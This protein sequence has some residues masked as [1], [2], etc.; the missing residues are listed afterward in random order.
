MRSDLLSRGTFLSAVMWAAAASAQFVPVDPEQCSVTIRTDQPVSIL[1][2]PDAFGTPLSQARLF[3]GG[4]TD[5]TIDVILRDENGD[6][7]EY[8][9]DIDLWLVSPDLEFCVIA[10]TADLSTGSD[11]WTCFR[12]PRRASGTMYEP[13]LRVYY[14][15]DPLGDGPIPFLRANSPDFNGNGIVDLIDAGYFAQ[16]YHAQDYA[17]DFAWDGRLDLADVSIMAGHL[18]HV[19]Y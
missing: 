17:A 7:V 5:A 4:T 6:P 14:N 16:A 1:V 3:G 8:V 13:S 19:C 15:G 9:S 11:G 18:G 12:R 10:N 2:C